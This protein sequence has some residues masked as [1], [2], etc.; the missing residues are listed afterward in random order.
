MRLSA[1]ALLFG[2]FLA[3]CI[4]TW[5]SYT[6]DD[7][8]GPVV[9]VL[10]GSPKLPLRDQLLGELAKIA[11]DEQWFDEAFLAT[12]KIEHNDFRDETK[13]QVIQ[14]VIKEI[15]KDKEKR[16]EL[17]GKAVSESQTLQKS[18]T[19]SLTYARIAEELS[20]ADNPDRN[21]IHEYFKRAISIAE[22]IPKDER[23]DDNSGVST[24]NRVAN[25]NSWLF[26]GFLAALSFVSVN[27]LG[28]LFKEIGK[29]I[30]LKLSV[31]RK[32]EE[33][34]SEDKSEA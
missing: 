21:L 15:S 10:D 9:G 2:I 23:A 17:I 30:A 8:D 20:R 27:L 13:D 1:L 29:G 18:R 6:A 7:R 28:E 11:A 12:S 14:E 4:F 34:E 3:A 31:L 25:G 22:D 26:T 5:P 19:K 32:A 33:V 24:S 16:D